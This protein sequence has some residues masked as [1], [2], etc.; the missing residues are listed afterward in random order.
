MP[1]LCDTLAAAAQHCQTFRNAK[2][3][4]PGLNAYLI[5]ASLGVGRSARLRL[6][7]VEV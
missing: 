4:H 6:S 2:A 7:R 5:A 3:R 1:N